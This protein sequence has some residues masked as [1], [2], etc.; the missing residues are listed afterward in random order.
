MCVL[1]VM[2]A[3]HARATLEA[4]YSLQR[5]AGERGRVGV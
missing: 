4:H 2:G 1:E 3:T 5:M